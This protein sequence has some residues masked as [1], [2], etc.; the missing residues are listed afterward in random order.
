MESGVIIAEGKTKTIYS[1][2]GD[3]RFCIIENKLDITAFDDPAFTKQFDNK[4]KYA[5]S[6]AC[7][8]FKLLKKKGVPIAFV[9]KF[10]AT[11]FVAKKCQ[12]IPLEVVARR[13][14]VG[15][16]LKRFPDMERPKGEKP[17]H[18]ENIVV[19]FFLKTTHGCL[20]I[21]GKKIISGLD[22]LSGEEDPWIENPI[23]HLWT[24]RHSKKATNDTSGIL[25]NEIY[26]PKRWADFSHIEQMTDITKSV[27]YTLELAWQ[28]LGFHL[29]DMKIEF[30]ETHNGELVIADVI[31]ND[32]WRLMTGDWEDVSKQSFRD[33]ESLETVKNKY[34]L[35]AELSEKFKEL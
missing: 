11:S 30:G 3:P 12:M 26:I 24:L 16:Y 14:A 22:P 25:R 32:S 19:E 27:F 4:A 35:V 18:F 2:Y 7:N 28:K 29:I 23:N 21:D 20:E 13:Y 15:S 34:Q 17:N 9:E 31:D 5:T 33:G 1:V 8:V 10:D 6:T